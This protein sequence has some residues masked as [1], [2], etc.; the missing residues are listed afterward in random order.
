LQTPD[1]SKILLAKNLIGSGFQNAQFEGTSTEFVDVVSSAFK[2][3]YRPINDL[4][5]LKYI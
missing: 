3:N 1:G 5:I 2:Y 4:A